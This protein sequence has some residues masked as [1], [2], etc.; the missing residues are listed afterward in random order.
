MGG[1]K[2]TRIKVTEEGYLAIER[3]GSF[4]IQLCSYNRHSSDPHHSNLLMKGGEKR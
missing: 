2:E 3:A 4:K 1:N